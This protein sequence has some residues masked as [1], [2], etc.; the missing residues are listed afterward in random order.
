MTYSVYLSPA[1]SSMANVR[2]VIDGTPNI[3]TVTAAG[4]SGP[5]DPRTLPTVTVHV[6]VDPALSPP[7]SPG[8][9][10]NGSGDDYSPPSVSSRSYVGS[11]ASD[12]SEDPLAG[13]PVH[14]YG[15]TT[16]FSPDAHSHPATIYGGSNIAQIDGADSDED[17]E[18][19]EGT[20]SK[21]PPTSQLTKAL[22]AASVATVPPPK[23]ISLGDFEKLKEMPVAA[24]INKPVADLLFPDGIKFH[25]GTPVQDT[26][27]AR[28]TFLRRIRHVEEDLSSVDPGSDAAAF[29]L[30]RDTTIKDLLAKLAAAFAKLPARQPDT[31][32]VCAMGKLV[33]GVEVFM[34]QMVD[35]MLANYGAIVA[36]ANHVIAEEGTSVSSQINRAIARF[37]SSLRSDFEADNRARCEVRDAL[38]RSYEAMLALSTVAVQEG[39]VFPAFNRAAID[40][41]RRDLTN[42]FKEANVLSASFSE[43]DLIG[44][45]VTIISTAKEHREATRRAA[46]SSAAATE[47]EKGAGNSSAS[48]TEK[49]STPRHG[50][51]VDYLVSHELL[52]SSLQLLGD[53]NIDM[54]PSADFLAQCKQAKA[55]K[56]PG[57]TFSRNPLKPA[58]NWEEDEDNYELGLHQA[59][60][61][62]RRDNRFRTV[63]LYVRSRD[64]NWLVPPSFCPRCATPLDGDHKADAC[65]QQVRETGC[66]YPPCPSKS[67]HLI[68]ACSYLHSCCSTCGCR[69]HDGNCTTLNDFTER[70]HEFEAHADGGLFTSH[71]YATR[72][73]EAIVGWGFFPVISW[74]HNVAY[75]PFADP[76]SRVLDQGRATADDEVDPAIVLATLVAE[77]EHIRA[78]PLITVA[79]IPYL[80]KQVGASSSA[81]HTSR[82]SSSGG[83]SSGHAAEDSWGRSRKDAA[84]HGSSSRQE[85][86]HS[87][88]SSGSHRGS[89]NRDRSSSAQPAKKRGKR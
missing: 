21:H 85:R 87:R 11:P 65:F 34:T 19:K 60:G 7:S 6:N 76:Y 82:A 74:N 36:L 86:G 66:S 24:W 54:V 50:L 41:A 64:R 57:Y 13:R 39:P 53:A 22:Q 3:V 84:Q 48:T 77:A 42:A 67:T 16:P 31:P 58:A 55:E 68:G 51:G 61:R 52:S 73:C 17:M 14:V 47:S 72:K 78:T 38:F 25:T 29:R 20:G 30:H 46:H 9:P 8:Y 59:L 81:G 43:P 70:F 5:C 79:V 75:L 26:A 28:E 89:S 56:Q 32:L 83:K 12:H 62:V 15:V 1:S 69:G 45:A 44:G 35:A 4:L 23:Q 71:R 80:E 10:D 88:S 18:E 27:A 40:R 37:E 49:K 33:A 2:I 63:R